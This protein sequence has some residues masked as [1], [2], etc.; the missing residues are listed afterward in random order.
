METVFQQIHKV[1]TSRFEIA[2]K[3]Y[4]ILF[5]LNNI[6]VTKGEL[7]LI[8][9]LAVHGTVSTPSVRK[10][11]E[12]TFG[13]PINS[14]YNMV[15]KLQKKRLLVKDKDNKIRVN[16]QILPDFSKGDLLLVIKIHSDGN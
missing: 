6:H 3:Y 8:S 16:P 15:S 2:Q 14:I 11:F 4:M 7:N 5:D 1:Y 9:F 13:A 10:L 12:E